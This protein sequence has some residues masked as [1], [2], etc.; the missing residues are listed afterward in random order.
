MDASPVVR[1]QYSRQL[2]SDAGNNAASDAQSPSNNESRTFDFPLNS[3]STA[4]TTESRT[5]LDNLVSAL[6]K[7]HSDMNVFLTE[8]MAKD[9]QDA[10]KAEKFKPDKPAAAAAASTNQDNGAE[11]EEEG[12]GEIDEEQLFDVEEPDDDI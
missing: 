7:T 8:Q 6:E 1:V 11:G 10:E 2:Q 5:Y 9:K 3:S 12:G 4:G